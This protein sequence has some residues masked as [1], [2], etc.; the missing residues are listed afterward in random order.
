MPV[1]TYGWDDDLTDLTRYSAQPHD[2]LPFWVPRIQ[3]QQVRCGEHF[4][5]IRAPVTE[6]ERAHQIL[7]S[8][9]GPVL[10]N[11]YTKIWYFLL[12][13]GLVTPQAWTVRGT[14]LMRAGALIA[15]PPASITYG[16][17]VR[18]VVLPEQGHTDPHALQQALEG[19]APAPVTPR[20]S[21]R[22]RTDTRPTPTSPC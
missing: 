22:S 19:H 14:R 15:I 11:F 7:G 8:H 16:R 3:T 4:E 17:D 20:R 10:A 9:S 1:E 13:P 2:G 5:A 6:A 21:R 12:E 18:W